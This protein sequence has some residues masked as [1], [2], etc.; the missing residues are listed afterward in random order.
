MPDLF[1]SGT[2]ISPDTGEEVFVIQFS[3]LQALVAYTMLQKY[4]QAQSLVWIFVLA[5]LA[6]NVVLLVFC[7]ILIVGAN[8]GVM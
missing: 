8:L 5:G 6:A 3:P 2:N 1:S 4:M 7:G